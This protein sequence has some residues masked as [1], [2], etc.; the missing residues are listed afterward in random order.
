METLASEEVPP[1]F[2]S[3]EITETRGFTAAA[4]F[5]ALTGSDSGHMRT[6]DTDLRVGDY[7]L[8]NTRRLRDQLVFF[9]PTTPQARPGSR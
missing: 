4:E 6:L 9:L 7:Q 3:Y 5:G 2:L 1:Y 8:D